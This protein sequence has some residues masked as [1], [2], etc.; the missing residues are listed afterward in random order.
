M[1]AHIITPGVTYGLSPNLDINLTLPLIQTSIDTDVLQIVPDPR[2][3]EFTLAPTDSNNRTSPLSSSDSSFGVGDFLL[4]A[5][6]VFVR[7]AEAN[8]AAQLG[9]SLP[10]GD[11]ENLQGTGDTRSPLYISVVSQ[12]VIPIGLCTLFQASGGL[13]PHEIWLSIVLG[14]FTR[15]LLSVVRFR[16]GKWRHIAVDIEPARP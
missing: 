13:E 1:H 11:P 2:L 8:L 14:H 9:L 6:Y 12:I 3:P 7:R 10:S 15:A 4:R 5:K 16:Q